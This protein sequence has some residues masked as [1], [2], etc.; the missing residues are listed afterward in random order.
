MGEE[1]RLKGKAIP[2]HETEADWL[3]SSY[4]PNQGEIVIYDVDESHAYERQK[5]G[6]GI[7][8]VK[9]LPFSGIRPLSNLLKEDG[10]DRKY[11]IKVGAELKQTTECSVDVPA[12]QGIVVRACKSATEYGW[13]SFIDDKGQPIEPPKYTE[14][15]IIKIPKV[16]RTDTTASWEPVEG[17]TYYEYL[18]GE[19]VQYHA[20]G[21]FIDTYNTVY[22]ERSKERGL[23]GAYSL[24]AS[25][26]AP[27]TPEP[28]RYA[29]G[30]RLDSIPIRLGNPGG[31]HPE[32]AGHIQVPKTITVP[33][34]ATQAEKDKINN[35]ATS[36]YYVD[37][38]DAAIRDDVNK[39]TSEMRVETNG[40]IPLI[41]QVE[42]GRIPFE[43]KKGL[44]A[45]AYPQNC[46]DYENFNLGTDQ[47][48]QLGTTNDIAFTDSPTSGAGLSLK[49]KENG[50]AF[51]YQIAST[52]NGNNG[53]IF[54]G[55]HVAYEGKKF[56]FETDACITKINTTATESTKW[57]FRFHLRDQSSLTSTAGRIWD[58]SASGG[59]IALSYSSKNGIYLN[60]ATIPSK[61]IA[62]GEWFNLRFEQIESELRIYINHE[63][64]CTKIVAK[65]VENGVSCLELQGRQVA[66]DSEILFDNTCM[67]M[68]DD[69]FF[70]GSIK[71]GGV[72]GRLPG[73]YI[74]VPEVPVSDEHAASKK[75]VD[76]ALNKTEF[77]KVGEGN[78]SIRA[79][80]AKTITNQTVEAWSP[81]NFTIDYT[82]HIDSYWSESPYMPDEWG[83]RYEK[84][85]NVTFSE[86]VPAG[87]SVQLAIYSVEDTERKYPKYITCAGPRTG[88]TIYP[89]DVGGWDAGYEEPGYLPDI[90]IEVGK[91]TKS[92]YTYKT[93][94]EM[95]AVPEEWTNA[96]KIYTQKET[97]DN[98]IQTLNTSNISAIDGNYIY[99]TDAINTSYKAISTDI[100]IPKDWDT[101]LITLTPI[102]AIFG[103]NNIGPLNYNVFIHGYDNTFSNCSRIIGNHIINE[104][105]GLIVGEYN[106]NTT[107]LFVVGAGSSTKRKDAIVVKKDGTVYINDSIPINQAA[108]DATNNKI[109]TLQEE[110]YSL[111]DKIIGLET[112]WVGTEGLTY[113]LNSKK[114]YA[115]C[116][117]L[118]T[119]TDRDIKIARTYQGKPVT[120]I[121]SYAFRDKKLNSIRIP[122][123]VTQCGL[124]SF[125]DAAKEV[126]CYGYARFAD[127]DNYIGESIS[128]FGERYSVDTDGGMNIEYRV[129]SDTYTENIYLV[130]SVDDYSEVDGL[131]GGWATGAEKHYDWQGEE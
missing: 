87:N 102:G 12:S 7:N 52:P 98:Y 5:I 17:A 3:L 46:Q 118:G 114:T 34:G 56:I 38:Q 77:I 1:K 111:Q 72:A 128:V 93:K 78:T 44:Y 76:N 68:N 25:V 39:L 50:K 66:Y 124:G 48:I 4:V 105:K 129:R 29:K 41:Q 30:G 31:E 27:R 113:T 14:T 71:P 16:T 75:Y 74:N 64:V 123:T 104:G 33:E 60:S 126:Y 26:E 110:I 24:S 42:P 96:K 22:V 100:E 55:N 112:G 21:S 119:A 95:S 125:H 99:V 32:Y 73:G 65:S 94:I 116:T 62:I 70:G 35:F 15:Y 11:L 2:K 120:D 115:I 13:F 59:N 40:E 90:I 37:Q 91:I 82:S 107:A 89:S 61:K 131:Y 121:E 83:T 79:L 92:N 127:Y 23:Y 57:F 106:Y 84:W 47:W 19:V 20:N 88:T 53:K 97:A 49:N 108:L 122:D 58:S 36:K 8:S 109:I 117:G 85:Y 81:S 45:Q 43:F 80:R 103:D 69:D 67:F 10:K 18:I 51:S 6:D 63:L 130:G 101:E 28:D 86:R 54:I 9:D